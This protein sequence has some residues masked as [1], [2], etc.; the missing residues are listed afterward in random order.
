MKHVQYVFGKCQ[1]L[2]ALYTNLK[3]FLAHT[4]GY[5]IKGRFAH[6]IV[7]VLAVAHQMLVVHI[8]LA[9]ALDPLV[10]LLERCH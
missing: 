4:C 5:D 6:P 8:V 2:D 9:Q 1:K 3:V 7:H 10:E